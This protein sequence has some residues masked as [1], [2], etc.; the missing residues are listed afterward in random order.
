MNVWKEAKKVNI[1]IT[2]DCVCEFKFELDENINK[3]VKKELANFMDFIESTY[4]LKTPIIVSFYNRDKLI[5]RNGKKVGFIFYWSDFKNYPNIY[6][7][8]DLPIIELPVNNDKWSMD[9]IITSFIEAL[10]MYWAWCLNIMS[11]E[12]ITD[13]SLVDSILME[14]RRQYPF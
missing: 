12:Y 1:N 9:E 14:Y 11:D 7:E 5:D 3:I 8:D 2:F 13:N 10:T 4:P 6:T